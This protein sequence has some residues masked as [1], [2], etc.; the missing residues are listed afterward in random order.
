[1]Q[2]FGTGMDDGTMCVEEQPSLQIG[3]DNALQELQ[4]QSNQVGEFAAIG[5]LYIAHYMNKSDQS[6]QSSNWP[7]VT[8]AR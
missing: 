1:L 8:M 4:G 7:Q 5:R 2:I 3:E 6:S